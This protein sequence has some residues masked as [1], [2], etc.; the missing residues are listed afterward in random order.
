MN[1]NHWHHCEPKECEGCND[2]I[3]PDD[4][5]QDVDGTYCEKCASELTVKCDYCEVRDFSEN[6]APSIPDGPT[7]C[8]CCAR[9]LA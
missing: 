9:D 3:C 4:V 1:P 2:E 7:L 8:D 6:M 5:A